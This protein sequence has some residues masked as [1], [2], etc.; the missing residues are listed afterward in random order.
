M[1]QRHGLLAGSLLTAPWFVANHLPLS[2]LPAWTW[3]SAAINLGLLAV[4]A[5]VMRYLLGMHYLDTGAACS[6]SACRHAAFN[7]SC[8]LGLAGWEYVGGLV[9][10]TVLVAAAR[11]TTKRAA[12]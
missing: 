7:A 5:P 11:R 9:V 6:P 8:G 2:F 4:A 1:M 12:R 3:H 10:L